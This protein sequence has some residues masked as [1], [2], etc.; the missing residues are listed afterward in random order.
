MSATRDSFPSQGESPSP[1]IEIPRWIP[2]ESPER[3]VEITQDL[4]LTTD[5]QW[6]W[7]AAA[8]AN[9]RTR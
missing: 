3:H 1:T 4:P 8:K 2:E 6:P 7:D 5:E 9:G